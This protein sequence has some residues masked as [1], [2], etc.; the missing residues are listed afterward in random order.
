MIPCCTELRS[1]SIQSAIPTESLLTRGVI[2]SAHND[3]LDP[4]AHHQNASSSATSLSSTT[5]NMSNKS[6]PVYFDSSSVQH[7][8]TYSLTID[9]SYRTITPRAGLQETDDE[10]IMASTASQSGQLFKL[11][12]NSCP[13]LEKLWV[14]RFQPVSVLGAPTDLRPRRQKKEPH[15]TAIHEHTTTKDITAQLPPIPPVFGMNTAGSPPSSVGAGRTAPNTMDSQTA[16][17]K[18]QS[19][20]FVG[21]TIPPQYLLTLIQYSLPNLTTLHLTQC[22][23]GQPL[24]TG[25]LDSLGKLCPGLKE[26][27]LH[28]TQFHGGA[29]TSNDILRL[30][31]RLNATALAG[32]RREAKDLIGQAD[33]PLGTLTKNGYGA[34]SISSSTA[35]TAGSSTSSN[36]YSS[37]SSVL[38]TLP[39]SDSSTSSLG[40]SSNGIDH[41]YHPHL[42]SSSLVGSASNQDQEQGHDNREEADMSS[43]TSLVSGLESISIW[44]THAVLDSDI[45][46]ELADRKRHP[47]LKRVDFGSEAVFDQGEELIRSLHLQRPELSACTWVGIG[48][49][50]DDRDD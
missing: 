34:P 43:S 49:T 14:S 44:F 29:V 25:F 10:T 6:Q 36:S 42:L 41:N 2:A 21:C 38:R 46:T 47:R 30:L 48:D 31:K 3:L 15:V 17:S 40:N 23:A 45:V 39:S 8:H 12:A 1:F 35:A 20:Q 16:H 19:L 11:L 5:P 28:A 24:G 33:F 27:T 7:S 9:P 18:V 32:E 22:W 13:K 37:S 4:F 26:L 50:G